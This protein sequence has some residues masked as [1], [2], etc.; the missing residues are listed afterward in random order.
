[1]IVVYVRHIETKTLSG[2]FWASNHDNLWWV[3]DQIGDPPAFEYRSVETRGGGMEVLS[4]I[5]TD[6]WERGDYKVSEDPSKFET[7]SFT[8]LFD[9]YATNHLT[10]KG[11]WRRFDFADTGHGGIAQLKR[12]KEENEII[13]KLDRDNNDLDDWK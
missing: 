10:K 4:D 13:S 3:V 1:M 8:V 9:E 11:T 7:R 12:Q 6:I 2:I 5:N